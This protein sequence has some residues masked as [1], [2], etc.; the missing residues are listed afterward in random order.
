MSLVI[1]IL[2]IEIILCFWGAVLLNFPGTQ[3]LFQCPNRYIFHGAE[4]Y[5]CSEDETTSSSDTEDS[6]CSSSGL[7]EQESD[8]EEEC[9]PGPFPRPEEGGV[10]E[11]VDENKCTSSIH[12]DSIMKNLTE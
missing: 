6:C 3:F 4:V 9:T 8:V 1:C 10:E 2:I 11:T 7:E 12:T 5:S